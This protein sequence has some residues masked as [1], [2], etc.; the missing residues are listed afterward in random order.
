M[1]IN[2]SKSFQRLSSSSSYDAF[3]ISLIL[4]KEFLLDFFGMGNFINAIVCALILFRVCTYSWR[5]PK[6]ALIGMCIPLVLFILSVAADGD[7]VIALKNALR[8]SQVQFYGIYVLFLLKARPNYTVKLYESCGVLMNALLGLN[9]IIMLV[10][11]SYPGIIQPVSD[12]N[13]ISFEDNISG[14]FGYGSTHAVALFTVFVLVSDIPLIA[15]SSG[16]KR[17]GI[18]FCTFGLAALSLYIATLNDNKALIFVIALVLFV[19]LIVMM[20][21]HLR[22][23]LKALVLIAIVGSVVSVVAFNLIPAFRSFVGGIIWWAQAIV[24]AMRP[25]AYVNGSDE[26][27][28]MIVYALSLPTSWI[29]GEGIGSADFYQPGLHGFNHFG[30]SDYGSIIVLCGVWAY[31]LLVA[32]YVAIFSAASSKKGLARAPLVCGLTILFVAISIYVQPFTQVRIAI[33]LLLLALAISM[34]WNEQ[35]RAMASDG[36]MT[37]PD[38]EALR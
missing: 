30:Q 16:K 35:E 8:I 38:R 11:Y 26:R 4:A 36:S 19:M 3:L 6:Y 13:I 14:L 22:T 34:F 29:L 2:L 31:I 32:Y 24:D 15:R 12:G 37:Q 23:A 28:K 7:P 27:F 33:P 9:C 18:I 25:D 10:Q 5:I 21:F 1:N 17:V 20:A